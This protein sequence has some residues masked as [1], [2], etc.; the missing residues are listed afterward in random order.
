MCELFVIVG[1]EKG[2]GVVIVLIGVNV[3]DCVNSFP[4]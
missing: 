2:G 4:P 1:G 3:L